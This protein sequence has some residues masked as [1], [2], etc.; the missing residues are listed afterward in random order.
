VRDVWSVFQDKLGELT[1]VG[2]PAWRKNNAVIS[3]EARDVLRG[4]RRFGL[5]YA[6][7]PYTKDQYSRY[8]HLYE[9]LYRYDYPVS[10]GAGRYRDDRFVS[11]FS[12]RSKVVTAFV[13]LAELVSSRD[14]PLILSYPSNGLLVSAG[15]DLRELLADHFVHVN[16]VSVETNHSTLGARGGRQ[17]KPATENLYVC[18]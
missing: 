18:T 11:D 15:V 5:V 14:V 2:S 7:P 13:E 1:L 4:R 9:T 12:L 8:Y 6:D 10:V 17:T 3:Q 16:V